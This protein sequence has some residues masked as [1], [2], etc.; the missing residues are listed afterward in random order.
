MTNEPGTPG[1]KSKHLGSCHC[2]AVRLEAT[3][4]VSKGGT[5]CNCS[6][7]TKLGAFGTLL[8]PSELVVTAGE[9]KLTA[10]SFRDPAAH[11]YFCS[12]CGVYLF[13]RGDVPELGGPF[14]SVSLN[15]LD[16]VDPSTLPCLHWDGRHDNW[17]AGPRPT[18]WPIAAPR[19]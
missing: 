3:L 8:A 7:C 4:D 16:D 17:Q 11:R 5:R 14:A 10:Y 1:T 12:Q 9:S 19:A 18:P 15:I 2:G 6:I 13:G